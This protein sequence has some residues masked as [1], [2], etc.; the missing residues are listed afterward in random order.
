MQFKENLFNRILNKLIKG[1]KL[2]REQEAWNRL[3]DERNA[4]RRLARDRK[5]LKQQLRR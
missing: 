3:V 1:R 2:R 4:K 5:T